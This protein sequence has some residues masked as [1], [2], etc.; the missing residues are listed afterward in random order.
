MNNSNIYELVLTI[1]VVIAIIFIMIIINNIK[2]NNLQKCEIIMSKSVST[3][4]QIS[5]NGIE[6]LE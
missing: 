2:C 1:N 6:Y 5:R 3:P 4:L